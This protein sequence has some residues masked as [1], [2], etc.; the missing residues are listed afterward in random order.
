MQHSSSAPLLSAG[1]AAMGGHS[2]V[3]RK[4]TQNMCYVPLWESNP[5]QLKPGQNDPRFRDLYVKASRPLAST[6][7]DEDNQKG[8]L[9]SRQMANLTNDDDYKFKDKPFKPEEPSKKGGHDG[10][11]HWGGTS[12]AQH[13][14][15]SLNKPKKP[16]TPVPLPPPARAPPA[17]E[18]PAQTRAPPAVREAPSLKQSAADKSMIETPEPDVMLRLEQTCY[19]DDYGKPGTN[20]QDKFRHGNRSQK[21][22]LT[23]G[24]TKGTHHMPSYAG[25]IPSNTANPRVAEIEQGKTLRTTYNKSNITEE[26]HQNTIGYTGHVPTDARNDRGSRGPSRLTTYGRDYPTHPIGVFNPTF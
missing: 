24:T 17:Q 8:S 2:H 1:A 9:Y 14:N 19:W 4:I 11:A 5:I 26:M 10:A 13:S 16:A 23:I 20:P 21:T 22:H 25:F 3:P 15:E 12:H 6:Y 7:I 18:P